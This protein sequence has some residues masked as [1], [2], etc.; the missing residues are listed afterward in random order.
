[1][2][3]YVVLTFVSDQQILILFLQLGGNRQTHAIGL[4][5]G[6]ACLAKNHMY[7]GDEEAFSLRMLA[8]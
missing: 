6:L 4:G 1:M 8:S 5:N 7:Y 3:W 2:Q